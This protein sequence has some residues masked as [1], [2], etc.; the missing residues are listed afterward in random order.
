M[1]RRRGAPHLLLGAY[2]WLTLIRTLIVR[3]MATRFSGDALGFAWAIIIPVSWIIAI[4]L[5]FR[6]LG[7]TAPIDV[8]LPV[9]VATG[10]LPYL[11]FRGH[12]TSIL[13]CLRA[14]RHLITMGPAEADDI[15]TATSMLEGI[16]AVLVSVTVL[17]LT[18]IYAPVTLPHNPLGV[19]FAGGLAWG[20][21]ASFGRL[22]AMLSLWS[23]AIARIVPIILRPFFW[24]SGIFFV[25]AELP[26]DVAAILWW[27]PLL[28]VTETLRA[29]WFFG[30]E[31]SFA[32][33]IVPAAA[34]LVLYLTS[35]LVETAL[36]GVT[37]Q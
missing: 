32:A 20:L 33:P 8:A 6:F 34:I 19:L 1:T 13:R 29:A 7:R 5:F 14:H 16:V 11:I 30:V 15:L 36:D 21:G 27:N 25:A 37:V 10:M 12:V 2:N 24:I 18:M 26:A 28:H 23:G 3:D 4:T 31:S 22:A 9:F 35:R 17:S